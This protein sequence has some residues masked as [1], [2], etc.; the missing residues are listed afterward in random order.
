MADLYNCEFGEL[1]HTIPA[2]APVD[3]HTAGVTGL[4]VSMKDYQAVRVV[5]NYAAG[6]A[7]DEVAITVNQATSNAGANSKA[8]ACIS[9]VRKMIGAT[10]IGQSHAGIDTIV[11]QS[12][13][14]T[15]TPSSE[16]GDQAIYMFEVHAEQLDVADGFDYMQ[17]T[18]GAPNNSRLCALTY[19][20]FR[21]HHPQSVPVSPLS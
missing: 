3:S 2:A 19:D 7:S 8:C 9:R 5:V 13:A 15:Y 18:I 16:S 4:W 10:A 21:S 1:I 17:V 6:T 12:A 14:S 20:C 11:T